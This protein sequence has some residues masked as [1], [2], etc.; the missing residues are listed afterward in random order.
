[1]SHKQASAAEAAGRITLHLRLSG[2][3]Q[4][5]APAIAGRGV[6]VYVGYVPKAKKA[7][8]KS[9]LGHPITVRVTKRPGLKGD[10]AFPKSGVDG[11]SSGK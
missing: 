3:F 5:A 9:V 11:H 6:A 8:P 10:A 4:F 7:I 1:M 2:F